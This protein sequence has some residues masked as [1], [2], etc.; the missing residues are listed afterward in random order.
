MLVETELTRGL[1]G[2][3]VIDLVVGMLGEGD[4]A[5][6]QERRRGGL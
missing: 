5:L 1:G 3:A 6:L 2:A 4:A